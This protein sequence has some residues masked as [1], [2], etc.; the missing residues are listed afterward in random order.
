MTRLI[1]VAALSLVAAGGAGSGETRRTFWPDGTLR[2]SAQYRYG[3]LHGEYR[4]WYASG[5]PYEQRHYERGREAGTQQSW[6]ED[7]ELFLNYDV[8]GGRRY[9]Y[10]NARPCLPVAA[11]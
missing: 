2:T 7:G 8:R 9:G 5:R 4:S 6:T 10:V 11:R 3:V 1:V